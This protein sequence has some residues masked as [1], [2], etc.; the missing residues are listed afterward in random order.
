METKYGKKKYHWTFAGLM[1]KMRHLL[2]EQG[3]GGVDLTDADVCA[4]IIII[5]TNKVT[6]KDETGKTKVS[7]DLSKY[8]KK[9]FISSVESLFKVPT[10]KGRSAMLSNPFIRQ[11]WE[12]FC[13]ASRREHCF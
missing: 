7:D 1:K 10:R 11:L 13:H 12:R 6:V 5:Y 2:E 9:D 4:F 8:L 3:L